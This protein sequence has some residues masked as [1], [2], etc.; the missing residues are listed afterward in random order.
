MEFQELKDFLDFK[1]SHYE[2]LLFLESDP[3]QLPHRFDRKEDIEIVGFLVATIAWGNRKSIIK[4]GEQLLDLMNH[5]PFEY[6]TS[7]VPGS[8]SSSKFVH[9]TF[10]ADDLDQFIVALQQLYQNGGLEFAF[11][12][13][14][15]EDTMKER[16]HHFRSRF[17]EN[18]TLSRTHK[19]I[20]DPMRNSAAKRI[21]MFM[22]W[23][24][25]PASKGVDFGIWKSISPSELYLPLD[26]H[27]SKNARK[28]GILHRKQDDWRA[29]EEIMV[30]LR[31]MNPEDPV[32]YDFALF[33][34]GAFE[35]F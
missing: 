1:S 27:T 16:I 35:K 34:L 7:Y 22:R 33:G 10:N 5:E 24:V 23:M 11:R 2:N 9:R 21:N 20:S 6:V 32:K 3:I 12:K 31:A 26:V 19:H 14:T 30:Q 28:L 17:F 4:S 29:L 8:L 18:S 15:N 25:R 13:V